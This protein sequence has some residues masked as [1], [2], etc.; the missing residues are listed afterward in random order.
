MKSAKWVSV[1]GDVNWRE[2]GHT[3]VKESES[4]FTFVEIINL[5][6]YDPNFEFQYRVSECK[7][8]NNDIM[9]DSLDDALNYFGLPSDSSLKNKAHALFCYWGCSH[10]G[11]E[12]NDGNNAYKLLKGAGMSHPKSF[13]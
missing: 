1:I 10:L 2:Y 6:D 5:K 12:S 7:I 3:W 9:Q 11:G 8:S 4:G 13:A